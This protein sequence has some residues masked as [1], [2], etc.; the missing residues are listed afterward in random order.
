MRR[1]VGRAVPD[2]LGVKVRKKRRETAD[3]ETPAGYETRARHS[4][5]ESGLPSWQ[6]FAATGGPWRQDR[7]GHEY[8]VLAQSGARADTG[9]E[10]VTQSEVVALAEFALPGPGV[11]FSAMP[12]PL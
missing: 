9:I 6:E 7:R 10:T 1:Q 4:M 12:V 2:R 8:G 11:A 3:L 5:P